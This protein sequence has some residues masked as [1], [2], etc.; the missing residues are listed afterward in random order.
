MKRGQEQRAFTLVEL[1]VVIAIIAILASLLLPALARAKSKAQLIK[2]INN[3]RQIGIALCLYLDDSNDF[4]PAY[5]DWATWGGRKGT[6]N[7]PGTGPGYSLHGGNVDETK[8][9]LN[10]YTKAVELY[11]CPSDL[12]D[13]YWPEVKVN[14]WNG[15]GNSYLLQWYF[16]NYNVEF[17]G[18]LPSL[19]Y[20]GF[21]NP[22]ARDMEG[23]AGSSHGTPTWKSAIQQIWKSALRRNETCRMPRTMQVEYPVAVRHIMDAPPVPV[24]Q[25]SLQ[26]L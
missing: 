14:C 5:D 12:G 7:L 9:M 20:R 24:A 1:L 2:C 15:W 21:P 11:R 25:V 10:P 19:P 22:Q 8:R 23:I 17:V 3:Q 4:Y 18:G 16:D 6:N 26:S 13:P